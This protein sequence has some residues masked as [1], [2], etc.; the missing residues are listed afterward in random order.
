MPGPIL[1]DRPLQNLCTSLRGYARDARSDTTGPAATKP[2]WWRTGKVARGFVEARR[3][4][5]DVGPRSLARHVRRASAM[6]PCRAEGPGATRIPSLGLPGS[7]RKTAAS[8]RSDTTGP[9]A[10]KPLHEAA[11]IRRNEE[12]GRKTAEN[13]TYCAREQRTRA[14]HESDAGI[15]RASSPDARRMTRGAWRRQWARNA[16]RSRHD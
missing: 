8:A 3:R 9:A 15:L 10:T 12:F 5:V 1:P 13:A 11:G 7:I 16:Q 2:C 14:V 6:P 4:G